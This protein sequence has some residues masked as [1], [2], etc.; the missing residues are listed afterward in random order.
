MFGVGL[1]E[2]AMALTTGLVIV[3]HARM[4]IDAWQNPHS[5]PFRIIWSVIIITIP[6]VGPS[7]YWWFIK[8][9]KQKTAL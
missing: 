7:L 2:L 6:L 5:M 3:F 8:A 4:F 9:G 1:Q